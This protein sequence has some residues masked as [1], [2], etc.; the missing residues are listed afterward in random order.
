MDP[1]PLVTC[2]L[3]IDPSLQVWKWWVANRPNLF[4]IEQIGVP[5][6]T[7]NFPRFLT[8]GWSPRFTPFMSVELKCCSLSFSFSLPVFVFFESNP[9]LVR[10]L[11]TNA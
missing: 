1:D 5:P 2:M 7:Y 10:F 6:E 11:L 9:H 3:P 4:F 8:L